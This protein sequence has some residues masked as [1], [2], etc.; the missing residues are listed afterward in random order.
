M[1]SSLAW[2]RVNSMWLASVSGSTM[3]TRSVGC[4][5]LMNVVS[6]RRSGMVIPGS[7]WM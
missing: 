4:S 3:A 2:S 1:S 7:F 5:R 6:S